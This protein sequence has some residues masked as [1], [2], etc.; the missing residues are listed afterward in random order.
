MS[1]E[2]KSIS[3]LVNAV[4]EEMTR[5]DLQTNRVEAVSHRMEQPVVQTRQ[6]YGL[7]E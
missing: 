7:H 1:K 5:L 3:E 2:T 6:V 4:S